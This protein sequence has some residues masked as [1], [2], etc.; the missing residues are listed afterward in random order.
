MSDDTSVPQNPPHHR[1]DD[2]RIQ[3][4]VT[5][6]ADAKAAQGLMQASLD[7]NTNATT[8][9]KGT[10][11]EMKGTVEDIKDI[12]ITFKTLGKFAKWISSIGAA[13]IGLF[14]A[15]KGLKP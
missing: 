5:D 13:I 12:L 10:V 6:L 9:M 15:W 7:I 3:K 1:A 4:L 2:P 8:A 14:A 11:D